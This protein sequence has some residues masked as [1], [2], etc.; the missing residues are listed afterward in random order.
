MLQVTE[1]DP[2]LTSYTFDGLD[3][4][5]EYS[6]R[7]AGENSRG[8]GHFSDIAT[9]TTSARKKIRCPYAHI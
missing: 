8:T 9:S 1:Y 5:S 3:P 6:A 4:R 7:V 2:A